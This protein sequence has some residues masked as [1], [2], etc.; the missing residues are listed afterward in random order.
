MGSASVLQVG[1]LRH[2][3]TLLEP[4]SWWAARAGQ[5][6]GWGA[7]GWGAG[8]PAHDWGAIPSIP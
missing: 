4:R 3:V 1:K 8:V 7:E 5:D 2:E 6:C